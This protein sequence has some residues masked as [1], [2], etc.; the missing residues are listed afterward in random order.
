M[1]PVAFVIG[2]VALY[3]G[4][5]P[6]LRLLRGLPRNIPRE[7]PRLDR[8]P[9]LDDLLNRQPLTSSLDDAVTSVPFLDRFDPETAS[10]LL[11]LPFG[12]DDGVT[13]V[14]GLWEGQ[15]QSYCLKAGT[16]GP[17]RGDGYLWAPLKGPKA[18]VISAILSRSAFHPDVPQQ[19]VQVLLWGI[20]ARTKVSQLA[21]GPRKAAEALLTESQ[22][23]SIDGSALDIIPDDW[24]RK[25]TGPIA[26]PVRR[27]LEAENRLRQAF[28]NPGAAAYRPARADCGVERCSA[29]IRAR[30]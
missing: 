22:I 25:L 29:A 2:T 12:L 27:V 3:A 16:Y 4:D 28:A 24:L 10:P 7:I 8:L 5:G 14:P 18:D 21:A 17:S 11:E 30:A 26:E 20:I 1:L 23:A 13:L 9:S 6:Q 15:L 19:D